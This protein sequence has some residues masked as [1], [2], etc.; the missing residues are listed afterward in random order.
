[1][2]SKTLCKIEHGLFRKWI[3]CDLCK[4]YDP[5]SI[6][7]DECDRKRTCR[8]F[9]THTLG[10]Q[11]CCY[12][13]RK[14]PLKFVQFVKWIFKSIG[15][16]LFVIITLPIRP[17]LKMKAQNDYLKDKYEQLLLEKYNRNDEE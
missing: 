16:I 4:D 8:K 2:I 11:Y 17:I 3:R 5:Y 12:F 10:W 9:K 6:E 13:D 14:D 1:M 15:N 7:V